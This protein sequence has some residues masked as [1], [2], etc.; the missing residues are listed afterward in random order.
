MKRQLAKIYSNGQW[1]VIHDDSKTTNPYRVTLN[2]RKVVDYADFTSC[3]H[4]LT[5]MVLRSEYGHIR[6]VG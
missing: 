2:N 4:Y 6:L 1:R 3:M 5:E